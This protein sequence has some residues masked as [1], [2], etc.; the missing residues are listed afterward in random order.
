MFKFFKRLFCKHN[1]SYKELVATR[2]EATGDRYRIYRCVCNK[3]GKEEYKKEVIWPL[4]TF[5]LTIWILLYIIVLR[6]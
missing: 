5:L 2:Y 3:C 6:W 4:F 1:F